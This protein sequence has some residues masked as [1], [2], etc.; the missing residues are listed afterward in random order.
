MGKSF[1][2]NAQKTQSKVNPSGVPSLYSGIEHLLKPATASQTKPKVKPPPAP[3]FNFFSALIRPLIWIYEIPKRRQQAIAFAKAQQRA[4]QASLI[5]E[6]ERPEREAALSLGYTQNQIND[7]FT[8]LRDY[9]KIIKLVKCMP[10]LESPLNGYEIS[11]FLDNPSLVTP[12]SAPIRGPFYADLKVGTSQDDYENC[13]AVDAHLFGCLPLVPGKEL[14]RYAENYQIYYARGLGGTF[15][16]ESFFLWVENYKKFIASDDLACRTT[17]NHVPQHCGTF[18]HEKAKAD[19]DFH[20]LM[21]CRVLAREARKYQRAQIEQEDEPPTRI[22]PEPEPLSRFNL[23][24]EGKAMSG[25]YVGFSKE[26]PNEP[27]QYDGENHLV[28]IGPPGTGKSTRLLIPNLATLKRSILCID[29]KGEL[30]AV[31][32]QK[33]AKFGRVVIL[34]PFG[35]LVDECPYLKSHGFNP[36]ALLNPKSDDFVDDASAV[37]EGL[38]KIRGLD[39]HWAEG[40]QDFAAALIMH[41]RRK[42]GAAANL[43]M[44]RQLL[45]ETRG[46]RT[47]PKTNEKIPTGLE[48]TILD[49]LSC[50]YA[51]IEQKAGRFQSNSTEM[52]SVIS[53]AI[54]QTRYLDSPQI[55]RDLSSVNKF[56]FRSMRSGIVTV[57]LILPFERLETH[58][59]WFRLIVAIALRALTDSSNARYAGTSPPVL[60]MLDEF[61]QLGHMASIKTAMSSSR[62][63]RL[64]LWPMLQY[65]Q[66]LETLYGSAWET[67][68]A[69]A[70]FTSF[71]TPRDNFNSEYLSR[72][73]GTH[74]R[75][76]QSHT[77][78]DVGSMS[79]TVSTIIDPLFRPEFFLGMEEGN[80]VSFKEYRSSPVFLETPRYNDR[81]D[82]RLSAWCSDLAN[83][84]WHKT[85]KSPWG[86]LSAASANDRWKL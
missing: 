81:N 42:H 32:A 41:V 27:R 11:L 1:L 2:E 12:S 6:Q 58:S 61:A 34:N 39:E 47:D 37:A 8:R 56:D 72:R 29:P 62:G 74:E 19:Y 84:P 77:T 64:Q 24:T 79:K 5:Y 67:F 75:K 10:V 86:M 83:N 23:L 28:T 16:I 63:A 71:F 4:E 31:T 59:T 57:Y 21:L 40:G 44:V 43:H 49:M 70:G 50:G 82:R 53:A 55:Q 76:T 17:P 52:A 69:A 26:S 20:Y 14:S 33:R 22:R 80:L 46:A 78:S 18:E 54:S 15:T 48:A 30:A 51:P 25:I 36:L 38:I 9:E 35:T 45:T 73:S 13:Y 60:F 7:H 85:E 66:Q 65:L 3:R 68:L